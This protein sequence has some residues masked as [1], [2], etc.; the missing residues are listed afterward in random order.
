MKQR[1]KLQQAKHY[2]KNAK[3]LPKLNIG[4]TVYVQLKPNVRKWTP[5]I[6]IHTGLEDS[7]IYIYIVSKPYKE[8]SM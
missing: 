3:D 2:N 1:M 4:D 5:S 6:I 7:R 8:D